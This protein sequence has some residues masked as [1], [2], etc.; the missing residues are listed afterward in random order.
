MRE[1]LAILCTHSWVW[2]TPTVR[3]TPPCARVGHSLV[4]LSASADDGDGVALTLFGGRADGE[5]ALND[6]WALRPHC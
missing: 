5:R 6:T 3:G 2:S 4:P 1:D